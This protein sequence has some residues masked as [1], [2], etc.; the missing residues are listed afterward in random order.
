MKIGI[1]GAG[2]VGGALAWAI[3]KR[4]VNVG[5]IEDVYMYD[6]NVH[7]QNDVHPLLD[8]DIVFICVPTPSDSGEQDISAVGDCLYKLT[9][10]NGVVAIKS[11]ITPDNL[12][13]LVEVHDHLRIAANPE[14]LTEAN[15]NA[16]CVNAQFHII[17]AN[18]STIHQVLF[19][20]YTSLW[21]RSIVH[22][23]SLRSAMMAK[24]V[25]NSFLATKVAFMNEMARL[26]D[27]VSDGEPAQWQDIAYMLKFDERMGGTH[28]DVP[29]PD[30]KP[31]FGGKC[32]P[33]DTKAFAAMAYE[34]DATVR[35][36]RAAIDTNLGI[37]GI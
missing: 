14:F 17:G 36:L 8:T 1:M 21:P 4:D 10:Y 29:G 20:L 34:R 2:V 9:E 7:P 33:K 35:I 28:M 16:D 13:E 23:T 24:Y 37:R 30:G 25:I 5:L 26:W 32:L 15:A 27:R 18:D 22:M 3:E 6:P 11:T 12:G 19:Y 31:G